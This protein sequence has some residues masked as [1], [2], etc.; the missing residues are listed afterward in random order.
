MQSRNVGENSKKKRFFLLG[1]EKECVLVVV[2]VVVVMSVVVEGQAMRTAVAVISFDSWS[3]INVEDGLM[4]EEADS[5]WLLLGRCHPLAS[6]LDSLLPSSFSFSSSSSS[7]SSSPLPTIEKD[8]RATDDGFIREEVVL[9]W[10]GRVSRGSE[11]KD[12]LDVNKVSFSSVKLFCRLG[13]IMAFWSGLPGSLS[14]LLLLLLLWMLLLWMLLF[15]IL[16]FA[17]AKAK[18]SFFPTKLPC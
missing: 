1:P 17:L 5:M 2:V 3:V 10:G 18:N 14:L 11:L 15:S 8:I 7:S 12:D 13:L 16:V 6:L 9:D 4:S